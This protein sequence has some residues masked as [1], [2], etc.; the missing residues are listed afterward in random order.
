MQTRFP[1]RGN[2]RAA[3]APREV[4]DRAGIDPDEP[5]TL[6]AEAGRIVIAPAKRKP[7]LAVLPARIK[8]KDDFAEADYGPPA[9]R[10][11]KPS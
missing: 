5:A 9:G 4:L 7:V 1:K 11:G 8:P 2:S 10:K 6:S 3:R